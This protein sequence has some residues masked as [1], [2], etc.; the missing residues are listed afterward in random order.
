MN[1]IDPEFRVYADEINRRLADMFL[2]V[3]VLRPIVHPGT[4]KELMMVKLVEKHE[5]N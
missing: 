5:S 3:E 2:E 1:N 4:F